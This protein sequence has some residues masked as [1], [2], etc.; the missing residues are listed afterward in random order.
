M[1]FSGILLLLSCLGTGSAHALADDL[2]DSRLK[3][4]LR[5]VDDTNSPIADASVRITGLRRKVGRG[6][7]YVWNQRDHG[8]VSQVFTQDNGIAT[9]DCPKWVFEREET[10]TVTCR[11]EHPD[12]ISVTVD[13]R[14]DRGVVDVSLFRGF[15]L[16]A[17]AVNLSG[18]A[19]RQDL[20]GVLSGQHLQDEWRT[21]SNG[22]LMSRTIA[23]DRD[24]LWLVHLPPGGH[25][26]WSDL[27][28][29][30]THRKRSRVR[31]RNV[32]LHSGMILSGK[33][34]D[35]VPRPV[36]N[37]LVILTATQHTGLRDP[38]R[39]MRWQEYVSI[40]PDGTFEFPSL[41][42]DGFVQ[43]FAYCDGWNSAGPTAT[44]LE[45][46]GLAEFRSD[47]RRQ[48]L[49]PQ[50]LR[51]GPGQRTCDIP[52]LQSM[53]CLIRIVDADDQA[54]AG[55]SIATQPMQHWMSG[56]SEPAGDAMSTARLVKLPAAERSRISSFDSR[57]NLQALGVL[58]SRDSRYE[59]ISDRQ[60]QVVLKDLPATRSGAETSCKF[61]V[62]AAGQTTRLSEFRK[63]M[64]PG[65]SASLTIH[66]RE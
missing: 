51:L 28:K 47:L 31:L 30:S 56:G 59:Q 32:E 38:R 58:M 3:F 10:G 49:L 65:A 13:V 66:L 15:R 14:L 11:I 17:T 40:E 50:V 1:R 46:V 12:Y 19:I 4:Q 55:V 52:M 33:L 41:P 37:G 57:S 43:M 39:S 36:R 18:V 5:V 21:F 6:T 44:D 48:V 45:K 54:V 63:S 2:G 60:G 64:L 24:R 61:T 27:L 9:L 42:R 22:I 26:L 25:S 20:F 7:W 53:S 29:P 35:N 8:P 23:W 62:T 16:A 34:S